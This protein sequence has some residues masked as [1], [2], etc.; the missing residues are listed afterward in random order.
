MTTLIEHRTPDPFTHCS[1]AGL[2]GIVFMPPSVRQKI[3][4]QG[5]ASWPRRSRV[6]SIRP[7]EDIRRR[8]GRSFASLAY[9]WRSPL[10]ALDSQ[11]GVRPN[12]RG[13]GCRASRAMPAPR[14]FASRPCPERIAAWLTNRYGG[15]AVSRQDC[16]ARSR[17]GGWTRIAPSVGGEGQRGSISSARL[18]DRLRLG[19]RPVPSDAAIQLAQRPIGSVS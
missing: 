9:C 18:R 16:A 5:P 6:P 13:R 3:P 19:S 2:N 17:P 1:A 11:R 8:C 10:S 15:R 14:G 4:S 7:R 12:R